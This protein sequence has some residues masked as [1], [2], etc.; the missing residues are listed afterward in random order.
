[1]RILGASRLVISLGSLV[2]G[3]LSAGWSGQVYETKHLRCMHRIEVPMVDHF[4][5]VV[6]CQATSR[7]ALH[8]PN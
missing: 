2:L 7:F 3:W 1:M 8:D 5:P 6:G 4:G